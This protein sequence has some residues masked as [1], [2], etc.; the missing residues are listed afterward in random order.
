VATWGL[1]PLLAIV[2][3]AGLVV[4]ALAHRMSLLQFAG[5]QEVFWLGL[6]LAFV[7][8]AVRVSWDG[9]SRRESVTLVTMLGLVLYLF[10]VLHSPEWFTFHDEFMHWRTADDIVRTGQLFSDNP[11]LPAS[12]LYPSLEIVSA[13]LVQL[14]G[15]SIFHAGLVTVGLA[16]IVFVLALYLTFERLARSSRAA[17]LAVVVYMT[18]ANFMFLN[19]AFKYETIALTFV[20]LA[21][22]FTVR[23]ARERRRG[24]EFAAVAMLTAFVGAMSHHLSAIALTT[25]IGSWS[26]ATTALRSLTGRLRWRPPWHIF[27]GAA[28]ATAAWI[29]IVAPLTVGYLAPVLEGALGGGVEFISSRFGGTGAD[30]IGRTIIPSNEPEGTWERIVALAAVALVSLAVL[31]GAWQIVRRHARSPFL[32]VFLLALPIYPASLLLRLTDAGW[33]TA[34]RSSEFLYLALALP[35]ALGLLTLQRF[36][37]SPRVRMAVMAVVAGVLLIGGIR[38]GWRYE[39][40]LAGPYVCCDVPRAVDP[41]GVEAALLAPSALG[42]ESRVGGERVSS[43]LFGSYGRQWTMSTLSGGINPNWVLFSPTFDQD[44][45]GLLREGLVE[46]LIV[47][48]R[49]RTNPDGFEDYLAGA[50]VAQA[51][52]KYEAAGLDRV[53]DS[54]AIRIYRVDSLWRP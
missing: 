25:V 14:G 26:A 18:N 34:N 1:A 15:L 7:P 36:L 4:A 49:V 51:L 31:A 22:Y 40:R 8:I 13:A 33:E 54:G 5:A 3:C 2:A 6:L 53:F 48:S 21:M 16:R 52:S 28:I 46:Y 9:V 42:P 24:S 19:G 12:P 43:L 30:E 27:V 29:L 32:L 39:D 11:L 20:A 17:A 45:I 38:A 37:P 47:D 44:K 35:I 10:K 23:W 50:T 41:E